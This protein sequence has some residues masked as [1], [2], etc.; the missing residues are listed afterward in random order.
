MPDTKDPLEELVE[1]QDEMEQA[2]A[3]AK[4]GLPLKKIIV[5]AA[6]ICVAVG[7]AF[8][9]ASM[10]AGGDEQPNPNGKG[11]A[12]GVGDDGGGGKTQ[13]KPPKD[14]SD[15]NTFY[16]LENIIVNLAGNQ[17]RRYLKISMV[18]KLKNAETLA[19]IEA[20]RVFLTDKL[21]ILLSSKTIEQIDG[22]EKKL[23]LKREIRDEINNLL[24]VKDAV[25]EVL[26][27]VFMVQ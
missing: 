9:V 21:N 22:G 23:E 25:T 14:G 1:Q 18:L 20:R 15:S 16:N 4:P 26:F 5:F 12:A 19:S 6:V 13:T 8:A 11:V 17:A 3:P 2:T 24:G 7:A 27:T 10:L